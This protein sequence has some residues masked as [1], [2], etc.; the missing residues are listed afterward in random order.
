M[1]AP[2]HHRRA[3]SSARTHP[4][5]TWRRHHTH[6]RTVFFATA[7]LC[8]VATRTPIAP[9]SCVVGATATLCAEDT[10]DAASL[11]RRLLSY[12]RRLLPGL[13]RPE[14]VTVFG[15]NA[16]FFLGPWR[17]ARPQHLPLLLHVTTRP[18]RPVPVPVSG[19]SQGRAH[20][21]STSAG[22]GDRAQMRPAGDVSVASIR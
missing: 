20:I 18:G 15:Q 2:T 3:G 6:T 4:I 9:L 10:A 13:R 11:L 5:G 7:R 12:P 16:A 1:A 17:E 8:A 21:G 14:R 19:D 22:T